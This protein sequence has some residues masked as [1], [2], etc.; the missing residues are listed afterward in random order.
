MTSS[1]I[2]RFTPS[3]RMA[4]TY[5]AMAPFMGFFRDSAWSRRDPDH[6]DNCDFVFGNPH[7][8][9]LPGFVEALQRQIEPRDPQWY[10][11]KVNEPESQRIVAESL[12]ARR[13]VPF[14]PQ[15]VF[16]TNGA[17][18]AISVALSA[19]VEPGDEVVFVSPPWF[20]YEAMIAAQGA[21]PVRVKID[22]DSLDLD[23]AGIKA[24]LTDRTRAVIVNSP[25]NPTGRIFPKDTLD[26]LAN[27]LWEAGERH[28]RPVFLLSDESYGRIVY[29]GRD[30]PSP[31]ASYPLSLL[32]YTYGKTLLTPGQRIGYIALPPD[33]PQREPVRDALMAAQ[34]VT[35]FAFPNALLQHALA[36][37]E[38][39]SIDV[40]H[41]QRKRDLL[42]GELTA[43]GYEVNVPE[44]TF[45]LMVRSPI[46]D[47]TAFCDL[48]GEHRIYVLP[49]TTT[50]M[51][52]WFRLSLTASDEMIQRSLTGFE[53]ALAEAPR[54]AAG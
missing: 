29:D 49:G 53:A 38:T 33:M 17:F 16:L 28:G 13:G 15:D 40:G 6:P 51:P 43:M 2:P 21:T 39:L 5:R 24:A 36:D 8:L 18:A 26:A 25:H 10:A 41:L 11:Y 47:D 31:T 22:P 4:A 3:E 37:L 20:F 52:G 19:L 7:E 12:R 35:G 14:E 27:V 23:V 50:E 34:F 44:G 30:F 54:A 48:L 46:E 9:P 45:Y 42:V 32:L 1:S